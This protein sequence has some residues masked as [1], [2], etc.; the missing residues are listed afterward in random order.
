MSL[1]TVNKYYKTNVNDTEIKKIKE[2]NKKLK[3]EKESLTLIMKGQ[4]NVREE[5][6]KTYREQVEKLKEQF[7]VDKTIN[8][9]NTLNKEYE[10]LEI[11][12]KS[13]SNDFKQKDSYYQCQINAFRNIIK[14]KEHIF[15]IFANKVTKDMGFENFIRYLNNICIDN[16]DICIVELCDDLY[17]EVIA[18]TYHYF[19]EYWDEFKDDFHESEEHNDDDDYNEEFLNDY[20]N[21]C[22]EFMDWYINNELVYIDYTFDDDGNLYYYN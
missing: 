22:D 11:R 9:I 18:D 2:E 5:C 12:Y 17:I 19:T 3:E 14:E 13:L 4:D 1:L 6:I 15:N 21:W 10:E 8:M 7:A 16:Q 20:D